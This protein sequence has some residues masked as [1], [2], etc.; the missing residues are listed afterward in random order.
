MAALSKEDKALVKS[1]MEFIEWLKG[2]GLYW[3]MES[4]D[5]IRKM[6]Q[7]WVAM[8]EEQNG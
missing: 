2:K 5:T 1:Q 4:N 6:H 3:H 7:V 8:K